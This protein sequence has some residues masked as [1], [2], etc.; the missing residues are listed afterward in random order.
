MALAAPPRTRG[1]LCELH[2]PTGSFALYTPKEGI[3]VTRVRGSLSAEM[4][5]AW[6]GTIEPYFA[7]GERFDTFHDWEAMTSYDAGT[8]QLLTKWI[9]QRRGLVRS[10]RFLAGSKIVALGIATAALATTI[11]GVQLRVCGRREFD[12]ALAA[13]LDAR[14]FA[15]GA[16][17]PASA[18]RS[19]PQPI[20]R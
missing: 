3:A 17:P 10:A 13:A 14:P 18:D 16:I 20:V 2:E 19:G 4:A 11:S 8:R 7:S 9:V 6:I 1:E 5:R 12:E 15:L